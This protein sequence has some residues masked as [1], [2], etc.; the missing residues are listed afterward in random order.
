MASR[1]VFSPGAPSSDAHTLDDIDAK[2]TDVHEEEHKESERAVA[3]AH[4][5]GETGRE[6]HISFLVPMPEAH[7]FVSFT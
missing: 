6:R 2:L 1:S 4:R 3:P 7:M 5:G